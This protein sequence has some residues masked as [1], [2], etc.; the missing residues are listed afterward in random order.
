MAILDQQF[1]VSVPRCRGFLLLFITERV[2]AGSVLCPDI[3]AL[4][5]ALR[6]VVALPKHLESR[7]H[8]RGK[9]LTSVGFSKVV[10]SPNYLENFKKIKLIN[11]KHLRCKYQTSDGLSEIMFLTNHPENLQI[12]K[13]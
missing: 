6:G 8:Y 7:E 1:L 13:V 5:H 9:Y 2:N 10:F 11:K 4:P 12:Y 3:V